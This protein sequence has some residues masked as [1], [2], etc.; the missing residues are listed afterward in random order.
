MPE[1]QRYRKEIEEILAKS[2]KKPLPRK[3][4]NRMT[5]L[6]PIRNRAIQNR[7]YRGGTLLKPT[8][9]LLLGVLLLFASIFALNMYLFW[10]GLVVVIFSYILFFN[11]RKPRYEKRWRG[12]PIDDDASTT[13]DSRKW[14]WPNRN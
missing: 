6:T 11:K 5:V 14:H 10:S 13:R 1:E 8:N 4:R 12:H 3:K 9:L 2:S 7:N